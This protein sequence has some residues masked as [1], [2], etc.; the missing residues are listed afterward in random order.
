MA[1]EFR[2]PKAEDRKLQ[3]QGGKAASGLYYSEQQDEIQSF[4]H[5]MNRHNCNMP[6]SLN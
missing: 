2:Q 6:Y 3:S 1:E 4:P 5:K